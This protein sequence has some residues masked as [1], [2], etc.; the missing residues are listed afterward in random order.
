MNSFSNFNITV[1]TQGFEG[2]KIKMHKILNREIE[3]HQFEINDSKCFQEKGTGKCL[4][5]QIVFNDEKRIIFTSA[6]KL[7][8]AI[9]QIP[10]DQFPFKTT[11]IKDNDR[12]IFS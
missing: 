11:I 10:L 9:T 5:L 1:S 3:V 6:S 8:E 7:M 12:F 4:K 2:D